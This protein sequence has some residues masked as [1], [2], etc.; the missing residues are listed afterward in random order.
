MT[1][2]VTGATGT[3]GR[4]VVHQLAERGQPVR[5]L[6]RNPAGATMPAGVEI[7]GGEL[8]APETLGPALEGVTGLQLMSLA[9]DD[10]MP[11]QTT[12]EILAVASRPAC[13]PSRC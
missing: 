9:G 1:I 5:A 11:L 6:T 3:I 4:H 2:L 12:P 7:V 13:V 10:Y 8:T